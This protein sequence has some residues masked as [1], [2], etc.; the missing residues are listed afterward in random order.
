MAPIA[1]SAA[2]DTGADPDPDT[3]DTAEVA[4]VAASVAA[5]TLTGQPLPAV[6]FGF[7]RRHPAHWI[8]LGFGAGLAPRAPG[9]VGTLWAWATFLLLDRVL[10]PLGWAI[11]IGGGVLVGVWA[12]AVT[13]RHLGRPDPGAIVW[14]EVL[15]FWIVLWLVMPAG[16][17]A[18]ALAFVLFRAFD[19]LKPGPIGWADRRFKARNVATLGAREGFGI[20]FDDL[21]AAGCTLLVYAAGVWLWR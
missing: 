13:A 11:L 18:Q 16:L 14:D 4:R 10:D 17:L 9:T 7:M 19:A 6:D 8:A 3:G 2:A 5:A 21:I 12:C 20:L 15:G 1:P